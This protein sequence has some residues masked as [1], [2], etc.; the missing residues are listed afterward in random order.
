[1]DEVP[2]K[3]LAQLYLDPDAPCMYDVMQSLF[4]IDD[5][6]GF[7]VEKG[8]VSARC[9]PQDFLRSLS[10]CVVISPKFHTVIG[11]VRSTRMSD[12]KRLV[13]V[14]IAVTKKK[15]SDVAD[16][17]EQVKKRKNHNLRPSQSLLQTASETPLFICVGNDFLSAQV[18]KFTRKLF[19]IPLADLPQGDALLATNELAP[20]YLARLPVF[21]AAPS[22][23]GKTHVTACVGYAST[24]RCVPNKGEMCL[25]GDLSLLN[26][27]KY[28]ADGKLTEETWADNTL[29]V[30]VYTIPI[31]TDENLEQAGRTVAIPVFT[32]G[33]TRFKAPPPGA[34]VLE[35][36]HSNTL[37]EE[38]R[39]QQVER[40]TETAPPEN[41]T[42]NQDEATTET[43]E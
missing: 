34:H 25:M 39:K 24:V 1:M 22:D 17:L 40:V 12:D 31:C 2:I 42:E 15:T 26:P 5:V 28:D 38:A 11:F 32:Y 18:P 16:Y 4:D 19:S 37:E 7:T 14:D 35:G 30:H 20:R 6:M 3:A 43:N 29:R 23:D 21:L 13:L 36:E 8:H 41:E 33:D 10:Q 27:R 9:N